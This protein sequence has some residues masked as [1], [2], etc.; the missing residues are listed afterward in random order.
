[1]PALTNGSKNNDNE[2]KGS[3]NEEPEPPQ[4]PTPDL[5]IKTFREAI[6]SLIFFLSLE[7]S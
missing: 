6:A 7:D 5:K 2:E 1:M 4:S 3:N